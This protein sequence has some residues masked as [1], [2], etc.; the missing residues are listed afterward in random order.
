M[1][2]VIAPLFKNTPH[3]TGN[4]SE[5]GDIVASGG[6]LSVTTSG[7]ISG[8]VVFAGGEDDVGGPGQTGALGLGT[9]LTGA[10]FSSGSINNPAGTATEFVGQ[11]GTAIGTT[12]NANCEQVVASGGLAIGTVVNFDGVVLVALNGVTQGAMLTGLNAGNVA[13]EFVF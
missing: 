9:V 2:T 3:V 13:N 10:G 6:V 12:V 4:V 5:S 1:M 7:S 11:G 8:T